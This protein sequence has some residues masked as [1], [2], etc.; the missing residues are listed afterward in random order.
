MDDAFRLEGRLAVVTGGSRGIGIAIARAF[1][2]A[3]ARGVITA[4]NADQL[5]EAEAPCTLAK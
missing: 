4:R 2:D 5:R 3:G 1:V